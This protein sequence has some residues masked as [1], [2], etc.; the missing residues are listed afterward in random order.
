MD[1]TVRVD[2]S[3]ISDAIKEQNPWGSSDTYY[4]NILVGG[5][6]AGGKGFFGLSPLPFGTLLLGD[7]R[8]LYRNGDIRGI[9]TGIERALKAGKNVRVVGHSW[10][11]ADVANLA[12]DY[13]NA[14]FIACDPVSWFGVLDSLPKNLTIFR[15]D[16]KVPARRW[17]NRGAQIFGH[18]W[19]I[20]EK[21][22]G[23]TIIYHGNHVDGL[24]DALSRYNNDVRSERILR[25]LKSRPQP[26]HIDISKV[27]SLLK[28][29]DLLG[30]FMQ[31]VKQD[32]Q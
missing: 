25:G 7:N 20:I 4:H 18:Q 9:R 14:E 30:A 17:T 5:A 16:N 3:A 10:G 2:P 24:P 13:P 1:P 27:V 21:G 19:P 8:E 26:R 11:G 6:N 22:D 15:P 23:R 12:K 28:R 32:R 31:G 29:K